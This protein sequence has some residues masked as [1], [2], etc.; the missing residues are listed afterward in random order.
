MNDIM[1][2]SVS[3]AAKLGSIIVHIEEAAGQEGHVFDLMTV[4]SL[5]ADSEVQQ[6]LKKMRK[7][8]LLPVK[9]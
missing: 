3:L 9:R 2:P 6:W 1:R 4:R 7:A 5:I 8:A